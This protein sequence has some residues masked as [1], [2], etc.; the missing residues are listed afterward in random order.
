M[1]IRDAA[2]GDTPR[3]VAYWNPQIR[4]TAITFSTVQKDPEGLA[5]E[6]AAR[7]A[8]GKAFLVACDGD[9]ILGHATYFQFRGGPGYARS[10]EHT[11]VLHPQAWGRGTGRR[12]MSAIEE[13]ARSAGTHSMIAGVSSENPN[14]I[15]FHARIGYRHV[16]TIPEVGYKFGRWMDLVVMQKLLKVPP[17]NLNRS[18]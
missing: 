3:I 7:Q 12:L 1:N 17:D 8:D 16:A 10:M 2:A 13:H 5:A 11:V 9:D 15:A 6:I 18:L 14:G 4:D